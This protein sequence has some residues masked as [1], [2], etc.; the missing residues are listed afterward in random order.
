MA[1]TQEITQETE[2]Q[3][4]DV[5]SLTQYAASIGR[6]YPHVLVKLRRGE[7]DGAYRVGNTVLI[8]RATV[9]KDRAARMASAR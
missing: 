8:P 3:M 4:P 6:S 1:D 9:E 7:I 2:P 5:V